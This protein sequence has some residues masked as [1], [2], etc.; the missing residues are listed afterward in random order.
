MV[1]AQLAKADSV[2]DLWEFREKQIY[3]FRDKL[4]IKEEND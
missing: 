2:F 3:F 1:E 4:K